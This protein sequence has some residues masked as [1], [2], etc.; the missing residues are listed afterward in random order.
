MYVHF[1]VV[2]V[3]EYDGVAE[4]DTDSVLK[5]DNLVYVAQ[6]ECGKR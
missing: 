6:G 3:E 2:L 4:Y 5:F 1:R